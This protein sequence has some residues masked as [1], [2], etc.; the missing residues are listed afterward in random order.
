MPILCVLALGGALFVQPHTLCSSGTG[1]FVRVDEVNAGTS[2]LAGL[3]LTF[4]DL[5]RA[6]NAVVARDT[7]TEG[8]T[9]EHQYWV[10]QYFFLSSQPELQNNRYRTIFIHIC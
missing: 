3:R 10:G 9:T 2:I 5:F 4:I 6:V 8:T 1:A 7:L